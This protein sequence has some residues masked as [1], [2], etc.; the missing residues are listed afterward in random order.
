M[1]AV[2]FLHGFLMSPAIWAS[3]IEAIDGRLD[4]LALWQPGHG[5]APGLAPAADMED[6]SGWLVDRLAEAGMEEGPH[7]FVGH[8]MG[9]MLIMDY[10]R[11]FPDR[12][13][14]LVLVGTRARPW[15]EAELEGPLATAA[16]FEAPTGPP[17]EGLAQFARVL[18]SDGFLAQDPQWREAWIEQI[19][20]GDVAAMG[21][22]MRVLATRVDPTPAL[23]AARHPKLV[24]HGDADQAIS[25]A[26]GSQMASDL[27]PA[28][29]E[30]APG[31]GHCPPLETPDW[32]AGVLTGFLGHHG[33]LAR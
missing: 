15:S 26:E 24:V 16:A 33:W 20:A 4:T 12:V 19:Y 10:A 7:I 11:R 14:G 18:L 13:A 1:T 22:L 5:E 30:I 27:G 31:A 6:W 3:G 9:G 23:V 29:M 8:S 2:V 28:L 25:L 32:F 21:R 17:R